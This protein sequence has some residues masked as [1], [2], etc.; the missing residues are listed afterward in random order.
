MGGKREEREN[1]SDSLIF[2]AI[3]RHALLE[4]FTFQKL[5]SSLCLGS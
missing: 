3:S 5:T 2:N 1:E 4:N